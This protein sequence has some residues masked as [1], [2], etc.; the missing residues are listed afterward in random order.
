MFG[1]LGSAVAISLSFTVCCLVSLLL[2]RVMKVHEVQIWPCWPIQEW[3]TVPT[4]LQDAMQWDDIL[5]F[6]KLGL[7]GVLALTYWWF[8]ESM[9][10]IA[11]KIGMT[12]LCAHTV[13]YQMIPIL[14]MIPLGI[15]IGLSN[16]IGKILPVCINKAK[17]LVFYT[18]IFTIC[19]GGIISIFFYKYRVFLI[20]VF[21]KDESVAAL[22]ESFWSDAAIVVVLLFAFGCSA[23]IHRAL[24]IQWRMAVIIVLV[25]WVVGQ[26]LMVHRCLYNGGGVVAM[27]RILKW[28]FAIMDVLLILSFTSVSWQDISDSINANK[29]KL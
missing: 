24:G 29:G 16:R 6:M 15:S 9:T 27:Y 11:A 20:S 12:S 19:I 26:P 3:S 2:I 18:M 17:Q 8:W 21:T 13:A 5:K 7:G 28:L 10:L 22:C 14:F 23:G 4:F 25:L 1:F